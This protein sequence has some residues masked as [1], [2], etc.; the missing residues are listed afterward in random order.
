M[1]RKIKE[2]I[3]VPDPIEYLKLIDDY[4]PEAFS[5]CRSK[6]FP[7]FNYALLQESD[8][9]PIDLQDQIVQMER[10][11][12]G[13]DHSDGLNITDLC[14]NILTYYL[15]DVA[16][17][18]A[19]SRA[20]HYQKRGN[21]LLDS[22]L[23]GECTVQDIEDVLLITLAVLK[24]SKGEMGLKSCKPVQNPDF[25]LSQTDT[26][27]LDEMLDFALAVLDKPGFLKSRSKNVE[28]QNY[29]AFSYVI[30]VILFCHM[31]Q[32]RGAFVQGEV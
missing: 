25:E 29:Y 18:E 23:S 3:S 17:I 19:N 28:I 5:L 1:A 7:F 30:F 4:G 6:L 8:V 2:E 24:P 21:Q 9:R 27:I 13:C 15:Q 22:I 12:F 20:D 31:L 32:Q 16:T 26:E 10:N 11:I 14:A